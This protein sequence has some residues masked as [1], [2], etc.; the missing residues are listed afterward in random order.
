LAFIAAH[1]AGTVE[2]SAFN[3]DLVHLPE[4]TIDRKLISANSNPNPNH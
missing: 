3:M 2:H 4:W 1:A